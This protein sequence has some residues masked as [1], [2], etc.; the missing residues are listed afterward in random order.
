MAIYKTT[1]DTPVFRRNP[2][3]K[4]Q[5]D[6]FIQVRTIPKGSSINILSFGNIPFGTGGVEQIAILDANDEIV[7]YANTLV[8]FEASLPSAEDT[9]KRTTGGRNVTTEETPAPKTPTTNSLLPI[10]AVIV[11]AAVLFKKFG[12]KKPS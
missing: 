12:K 11:I 4:G 2:A 1:I 3:A 9:L 5:G 10:A 7:K 6:A 8:P